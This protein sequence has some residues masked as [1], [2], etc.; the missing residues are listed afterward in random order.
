M[1]FEPTGVLAEQFG[2]IVRRDYERWGQLIRE[3]NIRAD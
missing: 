1:G 3:N 2:E